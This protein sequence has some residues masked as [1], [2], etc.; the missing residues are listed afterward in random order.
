MENDVQC[1][2]FGPNSKNC[3]KVQ[4]GKY[5]KFKNIYLRIYARTGCE[6]CTRFIFTQKGDW[7]RNHAKNCDFCTGLTYVKLGMTH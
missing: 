6:T 2:R 4:G 5:R 7:L 3:L 1:E